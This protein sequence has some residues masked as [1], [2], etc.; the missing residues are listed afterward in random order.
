[1]Q[2]AELNGRAESELREL[3]SIISQLRR[4]AHRAGNFKTSTQT[5]GKNGLVV[6]VVVPD[7]QG[8]LNDAEA[9]AL[10]GVIAD[11]RKHVAL[12]EKWSIKYEKTPAGDD[13]EVGLGRELTLAL[14]FPAKD[15]PEETPQKPPAKRKQGDG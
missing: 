1:M 6:K 11:L 12:A 10:D 7:Q 14:T 3:H 2:L 5:A 15:E 13:G 9:A 4:A 8:E